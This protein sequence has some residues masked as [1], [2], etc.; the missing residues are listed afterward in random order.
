ML[1]ELCLASV[2][3]S[4]VYA[5]PTQPCDSSTNLLPITDQAD[6]ADGVYYVCDNGN[7]KRMSCK[8]GQV[9]D[10][11]VNACV[12]MYPGYRCDQQVNLKERFM[13]ACRN[14][15]NMSVVDPN[16][17]RRFISCHKG[18]YRDVLSCPSDLYFSEEKQYCDYKHNVKCI[19]PKEAVIEGCVPK[20]HS[21][22]CNRFIE[23]DR[24]EPIERQ[25]ESPITFYSNT[26]KVCVWKYQLT[27][28]EKADCGL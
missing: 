21:K 1:V 17:C 28:E 4:A 13:D 6:C 2:L 18:E 8:T 22:D 20:A 14:K 9:W 26:L 23:C 5:V 12:R 7:W 16:D 11:D 15:G 10:R 27:D 24:K 25:C 19:Q 3:C